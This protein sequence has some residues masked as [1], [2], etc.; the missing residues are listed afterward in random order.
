LAIT[1]TIDAWTFV[2]L[3]L[4]QLKNPH[5]VA[6]GRDILKLSAGRIQHD[7]RRIDIDSFDAPVT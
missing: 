1:Q 5:A 7:A 2:G 3:N 4:E 6:R